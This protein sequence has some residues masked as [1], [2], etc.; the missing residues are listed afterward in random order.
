FPPKIL[1]CSYICELRFYPPIDHSKQAKAFV[2][3]F[4]LRASFFKL[5]KEKSSI[6]ASLIVLVFF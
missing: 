3:G 5:K 4:K 6:F 2:V 1:F